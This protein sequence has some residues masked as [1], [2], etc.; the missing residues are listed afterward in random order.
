MSVLFALLLNAALAKS[1]CYLFENRQQCFIKAGNA[2]LSLDCKVSGQS[3]GCDAAKALAKAPGVTLPPD[4]LKGG[5]NP[6]AALC[7]QLDGMIRIG[8]DRAGNQTCFCAF[9]DKSLTSC[10]SLWKTRAD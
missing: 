6:G 1:T 5:K 3:Y 9:D 4:A 2:L 8:R 10:L 7:A